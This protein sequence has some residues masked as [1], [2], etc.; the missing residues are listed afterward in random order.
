MEVFIMVK[1]KALKV[2]NNKVVQETADWL[3]IVGG[4]NWGLSLFSLDLANL[5]NAP[6]LASVVYGVVGV[7]AVIK[8]LKKVNLV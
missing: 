3:L 1:I 6:A 8:L 4:L 2:L 5:V 7:S